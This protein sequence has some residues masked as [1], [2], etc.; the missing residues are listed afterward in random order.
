M[1]PECSED[2]GSLCEADE[3]RVTEDSVDIVTDIATDIVTDTTSAARERTRAA[4]R[5]QGTTIN[6]QKSV[7]NQLRIS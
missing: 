2:R 7:K 6:I 4:V 5:V 3:I 1:S